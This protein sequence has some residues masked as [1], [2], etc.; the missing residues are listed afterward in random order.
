[1]Q[2]AANVPDVHAILGDRC[3]AS[4]HVY[5]DASSKSMTPQDACTNW[6]AAT[7]LGGGSKFIALLH[8][9]GHRKLKKRESGNGGY[10]RD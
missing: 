3:F 9:C 8:L 5:Y 7:R 2:V 6:C 1:M 10:C 4:H